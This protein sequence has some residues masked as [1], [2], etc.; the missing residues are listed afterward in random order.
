MSAKDRVSITACEDGP[1]LVRGNVVIAQE[2]GEEIPARR[3]TIALC[4]CG[5]STIKPMCDGTHRLVGFRT[6]P[7]KDARAE[8]TD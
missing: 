7:E 2:D 8:R 5:V 6:G 4:R 1:L 3:R